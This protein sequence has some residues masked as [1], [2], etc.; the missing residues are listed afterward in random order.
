MTAGYLI[1]DFAVGELDLLIQQPDLISV[2]AAQSVPSIV[3]G[4][5]NGR[6]V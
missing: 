5:V 1:P 2:H 4:S 3:E 6:S